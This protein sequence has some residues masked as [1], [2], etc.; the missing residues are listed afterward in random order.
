M[1]KILYA[2]ANNKGAE[3][4]LSR[5]LKAISDKPYIIKKAAYI[6]SSPKGISIDWTLDCLLNIYKPDYLSLDNDNFSIYVDQIKHFKPDLIISDLEYF[7]SQAAMICNIPLWQC[8]S[9]MINFAL[10]KDDKYN[11]G[12][13]KLYS[14]IVNKNP[15]NTQRTVN[16]I[17]NSNKNLI[18]SHLGDLE[19]PPILNSNFEWVRPY[20]HIG[21]ISKPCQ[22]HIVAT[23]LN[24]NKKLINL[25]KSYSDSVIF[26]NLPYEEHL[27][28]KMKDIS[29]ES[30]YAC[31]LANCH[32]F[33]CEGQ[34]V[35]L[36]DAFYNNRYS[37]IHTDVYDPECIINTA[38]SEKMKLGTS[39]YND[40]IHLDNF[41]NYKIY[42][43]DNKVLFL[44]EKINNYL[45]GL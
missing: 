36:A 26:S 6:K 33:M 29:N 16:L 39:I 30:E 17:D 35:F 4:Q 37:V 22:H 10:S 40:K 41:L 8:N 43:H 34:T 11:I 14:Y 38:F 44:H 9:S 19:S 1:L 18:Y 21:K 23:T 32:I 42:A 27:N 28:I 20:F 15:L 25:L 7:T 3:L 31:N 5:F 24:N 13:F 12:I 45:K 2:A